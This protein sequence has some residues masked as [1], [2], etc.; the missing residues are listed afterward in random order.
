ML[1]IDLQTS[2]ARAFVS[3]SARKYD[4]AAL[5]NYIAPQ[6][7]SDGLS[8]ELAAA[9]LDLP[10]KQKQVIELLKV[11]TFSV[12]EVAVKLN[13]SESLV[14]V[15]AHRAYKVLRRRLGVR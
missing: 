6:Q 14:K 10:E 2:C 12:R 3:P 13:M 11:Q 7:N 4:E 8:D 1:N 5:M 9:V 15:T